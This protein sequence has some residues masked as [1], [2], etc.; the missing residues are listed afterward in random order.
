MYTPLSAA[1]PPTAL[2]PL[3]AAVVQDIDANYAHP[4]LPAAVLRRANCSPRHLARIFRREMGETMGHYL[5]RVRVG[6]A[7]ALIERG[8]KIEA[9]SLLVGYRSAATLFRHFQRFLGAT[10][11]QYVGAASEPADR[12]CCPVART[13]A[14]IDAHYPERLTLNRLAA[15]AGSSR[16]QLTTRFEREVGRTV[17]AYLTEV[18]IRHGAALVMSGERIESVSLLVG[19][20]SKKN[21][22]RAFKALMRMSPLEYRA[23]G[24]HHATIASSK[25]A[26]S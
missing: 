7:A 8:E 10:P 5:A 2:S 20:R 3:V 4:A 23:R 25:S 6:R 26:E 16:R 15:L 1:A 14:F 13:K 22:Y 21:F 24:P 17:H 19:Y 12:M 9:V 18:R 11:R